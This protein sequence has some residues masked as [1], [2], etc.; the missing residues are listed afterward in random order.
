MLRCKTNYTNAPEWSFSEVRQE[1]PIRKDRKGT[2]HLKGIKLWRN[3]P[4]SSRTN[5]PVAL[6]DQNSTSP[7]MHRPERAQV[8]IYT[9]RWCSQHSWFRKGV[10]SVDMRNI[11]HR[12]FK[13]QIGKKNFKLL[14]LEL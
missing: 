5:P 10:T 12:H 13:S 14:S 1:L 6:Y 7:E 9:C 2:L 8:V 4:I 3:S 11:E